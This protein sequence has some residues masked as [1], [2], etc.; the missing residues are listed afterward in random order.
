MSGVSALRPGDPESLGSY[1]LTGFLGEGGQGTVY[2]AEGPDGR[3][4]AV[5]TLHIRRARELDLLRRFQREVDNTRQVAS[6]CTA[7]VL[8]VDMLHRP[9]YV[10]S[11]YI[12]GSSLQDA[13]RSEGPREPGALTRL[14]ISTSAA[15]VA[16]H[17]AGVVHRDFKPGNVLLGPD[18]PRVVDFGIASVTEADT[19]FSGPVGTP[20]YM[21]PEQIEGKSVGPAADM[22]SWAATMAFAATGQPL[23]GGGNVMAILNRVLNAAPDLSEVPKELQ[24][25]LAACLNRDPA[26][27]PTAE[28]VHSN[29]LGAPKAIPAAGPREQ[30]AGTRSGRGRAGRKPVIL[31]VSTAAVAVAAAIVLTTTNLLPGGA[32]VGSGPGAASGGR[33]TTLVTPTITPGTAGPQ[34]SPLGSV[35]PVATSPPVKKPVRKKAAPDDPYWGGV[36]GSEVV[37]TWR[38]N[39]PQSVRL[40]SFNGESVSQILHLG[41][42]MGREQSVSVQIR[43]TATGPDLP[44]PKYGLRVPYADPG[45][46]V[47]VFLQQDLGRLLTVGKIRGK[48]R[49][50]QHVPLPPGFDPADEHLIKVVKNGS[51]YRIYLDGRLMQVRDFGQDPGTG[52]VGFIA[53][54]SKVDYSRLTV[55][56]ATAKP[57]I[58]TTS[59]RITDAPNVKDMYILIKD[60]RLMIDR[61][62]EHDSASTKALATWRIHPGFADPRCVSIESVSQ[63]GRYLTRQGFQV[64][65]GYPDG[66]ARFAGDATLCPKPGF[67]GAGVTY[68]SYVLSGRYLRHY[69]KELFLGNN[70]NSGKKFDQDTPGWKVA[71]SWNLVK[72]WNSR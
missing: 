64:G 14:A 20:G 17:R 33:T 7:R 35:S 34:A 12:E 21:A 9:P 51:L 71:V 41:H 66:T 67:A 42:R 56:A 47:H 1:R 25:I 16:I 55:G 50:S 31:A 22:F 28:Q 32:A 54:D 44:S 46:Y 63:P 72:A 40:T 52:R 68:E 3:P 11:E 13:V 60:Q 58:T 65:L 38:S 4:V 43:L 26:L 61:V 57:K 19:T 62:G 39:G 6:F 2:L 5:K 24:P 27:R 37:G 36:S 53:H 69:W 10:V 29:L 30:R 15:L 59:I 8:A 18:G 23:F 70:S 49:G 48:D 45:N